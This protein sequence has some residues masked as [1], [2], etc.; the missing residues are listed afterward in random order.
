MSDAQQTFERFSRETAWQPYY[1]LGTNPWN[2]E[3]VAHLY[4]RAAFGANWETTRTAVD[5]TP[6]AVVSALVS[7]PA[8]RRE[9]EDD[10][11]R[12]R[13]GVMASGEPKQ[14]QSL[15][16]YRM[17]YSPHPLEE[18]MTLF[19]HNH[20]ATSNAK[21]ADVAL[22]QRQHDV[23]RK[24]ALG[25][26][27][28]MLQEITR[29]PA[30]IL[31]LDSNTNKKG[32][33]NENYAREVF[34]LFSLGV[35][36]YTEQDIKEAARAL[37]GW[38]V[39]NGKAVFNPREF[40]DGEKTILGRKGHWA[41]GDVVRIALEQPACA[42]FI[43]RKLFRELVSETVE[44]SGDMLE[45]LAQEFRIRNYD[46]GWLVSKLL[47]S[48]VFYSTASIRQKVKSPIDFLVG[49][50][51]ML[52]GR[53]GTNAIAGQSE[54]LGQSLF[55]PPSVKG[56]DGGRDWITSST[57]LRRQ[58]IV[59]EITR[60]R[61]PARSADPAELTSKYNVKGD[62]E[63]VAFFLKLFLQNEQHDAAPRIAQHLEETRRRLYRQFHTE[64]YIEQQLAREAAHLVATLPEFQLG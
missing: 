44:P 37:T 21:V 30:M 47:R 25:N 5:S 56:W 24:H 35:G 11:R 27:G 32:K 63:T 54:A 19:W 60:G 46:I 12:L 8:D 53:V 20:F 36:N 10:Y 29:D 3:K 40:D 23:F 31:W 22:M 33:P 58:N 48:W 51:R 26:F 39:R 50:V 49:T 4:R 28:E 62:R 64:P 52:E 34:E 9:F 6:T 14:L 43:V 61:N 57:L 18:R 55:Y 13:D 42:R 15:W 16:L 59:H 1:P 2:A 41:A 45:P 7:G 38:D 17:L